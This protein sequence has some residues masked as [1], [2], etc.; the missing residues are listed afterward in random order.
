M[1]RFPQCVAGWLLTIIGCL[2]LGV[3]LV[4][5]WGMYLVVFGHKSVSPGGGEFAVALFGGVPTVLLSLALLGAASIRPAW[6]STASVIA[7]GAAGALLLSWV[8][9]IV[10]WPR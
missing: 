2:L 8:L 6:R 4:L 5:H 3:A 7:I 1:P 10:L 9:V